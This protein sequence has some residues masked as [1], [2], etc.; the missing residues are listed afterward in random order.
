VRDGLL[1]HLPKDY[2]V[3]TSALPEQVRDVF[4]RKRTL[5][6][7][8]SFG[9]IT[10]IGPKEAGQIDVATFRR[11]AAYSDGRHPDSVAFST[12]EFDAQRRDFTINGLFYDPLQDRVIDFVGGQEDLRRRVVRA[13]GDPSARIA[14]D[15]LRMLRAVRFAATFD[16]ELDPA[17]LEAIR[18]QAHELVIVSAERIAAEM[19][20]MLVNANRAIALRLLQ[21]TS[22]LEIVLPECAAWFEQDDRRQWLQ[23]Q[24]ILAALESPSF[25]TAL[26]ATVRTLR[27]PEQSS[28][29]FAER[30][31]GRWKLA[32]EER[33]ELTWLLQ[34]EA[35]IRSASQ[36]YWPKLQRV[37]ID[38]RAGHLLTYVAAIASVEDL[39]LAEVEFCREKR[40]LPPEVLDPLPL[41][42]G[43]DLKQLGIAP[44]PLYRD[45]LTKVRDAQLQAEVTTRDAALQL[46]RRLAVTKATT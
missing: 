13:I 40:R 8:Q 41:L 20:R 14:E 38:S 37:L 28:V 5:A 12:A 9:V 29:L 1:Q 21:E 36:A 22:L 33:D 15:K 24:A 35:T 34:E 11:D 26:A 16:F 3:A 42:S 27:P 43:E 31:C 10:V 7:G 18:R 2:D 19:R 4:G 32:N 23:T 46:A 45:L 30:I 25:A 39:S 17:T 44:G 6:I